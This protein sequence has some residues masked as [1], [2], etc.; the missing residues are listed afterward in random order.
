MNSIDIFL[1]HSSADAKVAKAL[2]DLLRD[3]FHI[4]PSK[5][6]CT[7]VEGYKLKTGA[8]TETQLRQEIHDARVFIG[9]LT[10]VSLESAYVLFELGA[11]WGSMQSYGVYNSGMIGFKG[12]I[13]PILAAGATGSIVRDPL[14][15]YNALSCEKAGDLHQLISEIGQ[16][17]GK[18]PGSA[19]AYQD[20]IDA[21]ISA[22][23][24]LKA[25]RK[26]EE[27]QRAT[28]GATLPSDSD[29][30]K[31]V[32]P[33]PSTAVNRSSS[34]SRTRKARPSSTKKK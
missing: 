22:S 26:K 25:K 28:K 10:E 13:F 31:P 30:K 19:A 11:R 1:S 21:L 8:H 32:T 3:A 27:N 16:E 17:L 33:R 6:R 9:L 34:K 14:K 5:I 29:S 4:E 7:S 2:I 23:R 12:K 18:Q 20:K 24:R 15:A